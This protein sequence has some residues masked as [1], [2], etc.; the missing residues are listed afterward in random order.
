MDHDAARHDECHAEHDATIGVLA[1]HDPGEERGEHSFQVEQQR[2]TGSAR[3]RQ[4]VQEKDGTEHPA[5]G[6]P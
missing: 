6:N 1:E 3:S 4:S 2:R 5:G